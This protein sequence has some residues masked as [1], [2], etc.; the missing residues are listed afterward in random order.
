MMTFWAR[1]IV[2][3]VWEVIE[4]WLYFKVEPI[5][6]LTDSMQDMRLQSIIPR[7]EQ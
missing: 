2:G 5:H 4:F 6:F 3:K 1:V 7:P